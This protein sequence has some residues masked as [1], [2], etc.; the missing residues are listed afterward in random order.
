MSG[1]G[2]LIDVALVS[3]LIAGQ[4]P[5]WAD[6]P[7][8]PVASAGT[9]NVIFRLGEAMVVRLPRDADAAEA[10]LKEQV[11]LS[12]F[13]DR[14]GLDIPAPIGLGEPGEGYPW[15]WAVCCWV[16]GSDA[17]SASIAGDTGSARALGAFLTALRGMD[18]ADGPRAGPAN[19]YRGVALRHLDQRVRD[20]L[21]QLEDD[22]NTAEATRV[23]EAGLSA[24]HHDAPRVWIHGDLH[25]GN[26]VVRDG[27]LAGVID[28]GLMG[29]GDPAVDLMAG[30]TV[31][32][33]DVR[34]TFLEAAGAGSAA[35]ARA[36]AWA[37][38]AGAVALPFYRNTNPTL[39]GIS[40][41]TLGRVLERP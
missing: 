19:N 33:A 36:R 34:E 21:I 31:F 24:A 38:Y 39:A 2:V 4:F 29:V 32:D 12:G 1:P 15:R 10:I 28:F 14:L 6:L 5:A 40:R 22:I 26:L 41:R 18:A 23:W 11:W 27:R 37:L 17:V 30:W 3:R 20:C 16:K 13:V 7:L 25:P 9:D 35:R 8:T